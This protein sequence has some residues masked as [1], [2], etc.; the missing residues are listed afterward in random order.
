MIQDNIPFLV[1]Q[2]DNDLLTAMPSAEHI[3]EVVFDM[4]DEAS[5]GPDAFSGCFFFNFYGKWWE[6][7][8]LIKCS[9][10]WS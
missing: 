3:K 1:S 9:F 4:N 8:L 5:P 7:I 10:F 2:Q 6:W